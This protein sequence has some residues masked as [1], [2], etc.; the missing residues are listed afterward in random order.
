MTK[1]QTWWKGL[2]RRDQRLLAVWLAAMAVA[3]LVWCWQAL[4]AA[5]ER[6]QGRL[7]LEQQALGTMRAQAE[8]LQLLKQRTTASHSAM[9]VNALALT[10]SMPKYE[11]RADMLQPT[12]DAAQVSLQGRVPFDKWVDWLAFVQKDMRLVLR[13]AKVSRFELPGLV[14]VQATLELRKD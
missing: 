12:G 14:D 1:L 7:Q 4:G 11:L 9:G 13:T 8:E 10:D 5:Q 3:A 6:L 2:P